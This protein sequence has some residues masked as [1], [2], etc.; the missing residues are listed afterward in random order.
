MQNNTQIKKT[1]HDGRWMVYKI[2]RVLTAVKHSMY[3]HLMRDGTEVA[4]NTYSSVKIE[5]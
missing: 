1:R 2:Q 3:L 4:P 5:S